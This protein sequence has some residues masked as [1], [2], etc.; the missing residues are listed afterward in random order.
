MPARGL[1][2]MTTLD[3]RHGERARIPCN[4]PVELTD[5]SRQA[6][7]F[8]AD[9][10]DLSVGGLSLR[11]PMLPEIGSHLYCS[12]EAM[13]GGAQVL[14]RGE[15]VWAQPSDAAG[16]EFGLRFIELDAKAQALID[17]MVA[18]RIARIETPFAGREPVL[19]NLEIENVDAPIAAR[20][21]R[22][23]GGDALFEQPLDLLTIGRAVV[24]HAG[25]SLVRGSLA[26][27]DLRMDGVTPMLALT[28][29][30]AQDAPRFGEFDWDGMSPDTEPDLAAPAGMAMPPDAS[31]ALQPEPGAGDMPRE[32]FAGAQARESFAGAQARREQ[33]QLSLEFRGAELEPGEAE[34][35]EGRALQLALEEDPYESEDLPLELPPMAAP[36]EA[37]IS[38]NFRAP[39]PDG[40]AHAAA[41]AQ[42]ETLLVQV[43]RVFASVLGF[44]QQ[45]SA[46]LLRALERLR[47]ARQRIALGAGRIVTR[48]RPRRTTTSAGSRE[49]FDSRGT[50]RLV[51][52]GVMSI[53]AVALFAYALL[54]G[55]SEDIPLHRHVV[56]EGADEQASTQAAQHD[57][58][59][60]PAA[61]AAQAQ[62]AAPGAAAPQPTAAILAAGVVPSG[63]PYAVD[64]RKAAAAKPAAPPVT[65][66]LIATATT[67]G[68]KQ[69]PNAKRFVL[70]MSG[71]VNALQG[72]ADASGFNIVIAGSRGVMRAAPI[73]DGNPNVAR[74]MILNHGDGSQLSVH[75]AP[76]KS[77]AFRVSAQGSSLEV[78][79]GL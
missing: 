43:L 24:A 45:L 42:D 59:V 63:S 1:A 71:P 79:I 58:P 39:E 70:R 48:A 2:M 36:S 33:D 12:F 17:E 77:P 52:L 66:K 68:H 46:P 26:R 31:F 72:S 55:A 44:F 60:Q 62:V 29:R 76:G 34:D 25:V 14:G 23:S 8:E 40:R 51:A 9:A 56:P 10:V 16:G 5:D 11:A 64:V 7:P 74:A 4:I 32:A 22:T 37:R 20:L 75:F 49:A 47:G 13:P 19:A 35:D 54:P 28:V 38:L 3:R 73:A 18:E 15:V 57:Q 61:S 6:L 41:D 50:L 53:G 30:L 27:V 65:G 21:V 78:L 67:F 69:V